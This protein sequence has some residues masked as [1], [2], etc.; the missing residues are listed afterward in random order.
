MKWLTKKS[1]KEDANASAPPK[2]METSNGNMEE[3]SVLTKESDTDTTKSDASPS[4]IKSLFHRKRSSA[5]KKEPGQ[6][7]NDEEE[8][9]KRSEDGDPATSPDENQNN[10]EI[11]FEEPKNPYRWTQFWGS[12]HNQQKSTTDMEESQE[13][14]TIEVQV[15]AGETSVQIFDSTQSFHKIPSFGTAN[16]PSLYEEAMDM[17]TGAILI[18]IF[19]DL[20]EMARNGVIDAPDL[21]Q[22]PTTVSQVM[23]A[24][25]VHKEALTERAFD[26]EDFGQRLTNLSDIQKKLQKKQ[27]ESCDNDTLTNMILQ[28]LQ[29]GPTE[30]PTK[31]MTQM[32]E[33]TLECFHDETSTNGVVYGIA[34][35]RF[36]KRVTICF[37]GSV[38]NQDF[39]TDSK[40]AQ[41]FMDNPTRQMAGDDE[42]VPDKIGI[43]S[44]FFQYLFRKD[45]QG[46]ERLEHIL[47]EAK[48]LLQANPGYSLYC[49]GHSLGGALASLCGF[50][51]ALDH[52]LL[53][54]GPVVVIS[55]A[56]PQVGNKA[57][58]EAFHMLERYRRLQYLRVSNTEDVITH[59][60]F[61][62]L[63]ATAFS[64]LLAAVFGP[65]NLYKH[66]GLQLE[67]KSVE[68]ENK[69]KTEHFKMCHSRGTTDIVDT[70]S[71]EF[72]RSIAAARLLVNSIKP[73]TSGDI[74]A[75]TK[76]HS[77][78]EY[79]ARLM[80]CKEYLSGVT[81]DQ[82]YQ[83]EAVVGAS[84]AREIC[85]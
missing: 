56:S 85:E 53:G 31:A 75:I 66:C 74:D 52:E 19:A 12:N 81:L 64:P 36:R 67:L 84:L 17:L 47:N 42:S 83:D 23:A 40:S 76:F 48:R 11:V 13:E 30:E 9:V 4:L 49:C 78:V 43:H 77:C 35:N 15:A 41:K 34:L 62:T 63:K 60:P 7:S 65:G 54:N 51:A 71:E 2:T 32:Q 46:K 79:E 73:L 3:G 28:M 55:V 82:L 39:V 6:A 21:L 38:T 72:K 58:C 22:D 18:Y 50:F 80:A 44:G 29:Q 16:R 45:D 27:Q 68:E 8:I 69:E 25:T 33:S 26:H 24:I 61:L 20:R 37:R 10:S 59:L 70:V 1:P 5:S 57:F 14:E